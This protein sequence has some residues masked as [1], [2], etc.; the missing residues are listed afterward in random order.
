MTILIDTNVILDVVGRDP[1]WTDWSRA[2]LNEAA[3]RDEIAINEV[4][5]AELSA[6]Y[7]RFEDL[8]EFIA[9]AGL[10]L[11]QTPRPALFLS[12]KAFQ[13]YRRRG[14]SRTGV[15]PDFFIGAH[16][17]AT[18]SPL[19]TRDPRRYRT[20]FPGIDLITPSVN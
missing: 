10:V 14:G 12:G 4:V 13:R 1:A 16:A 8:D 20:Y 9:R 11:V 17:V 6:G 5:Y 2:Q 18:D 7:R 15:L 3:M 19:I